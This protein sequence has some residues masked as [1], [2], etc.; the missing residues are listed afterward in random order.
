MEHFKGM[1]ID[2][3]REELNISDHNLVKTWFNIGI[4][5]KRQHGR[6]L[7]MKR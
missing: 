3:N 6:D 7:G 2:E 1:H 4:Q 5:E